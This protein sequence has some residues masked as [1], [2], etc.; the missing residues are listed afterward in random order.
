MKIKKI[1]KID[2]NGDVFN[3]RI[4]DDTELNHNYFA[5]N[6]C[7][8]NCH[9]A[10][11]ATIQS[12]L[13]RTLGSAK[14]RFGMSGTYPSDTSSEWLS[15]VSLHGPKLINISA[16]KLM[17]KGLI[18]PVKIKA[19]LLHHDNHKFAEGV[20]NIKKRGDGQKAW[21][22]EREYV[23]N[24]AKRKTFIKNLVDK[25][26]SNSLILF[27]TI[28]YGTEMFNFLKDNCQDKD[29]FYIDGSTSVEKRDYIKKKMEDTS[30]NPKIL[31]ASFGTTST[32]V[33]IKA[34][35]NII[36]AQAFKSD[37]VIRQSIGRG[38]RLHSEKNKLVVFDL[39]DV[40]H[41]EYK[42]ILI[43]QYESRRDD[44]YKKQKYPFDEIKVKL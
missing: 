12:V 32:G 26:K 22:L 33:N 44:I 16:K 7:V 24:S 37:Q 19:I 39:V 41:S 8:S 31:V 20:Y 1:S 14:I 11:A 40:F 5:N 43:K 25:F 10:K 23:A 27:H 17:D 38:L 6:L 42:T 28:E 18:S 2:Y 36:F 21:Q 29:I 15:I 35:T 13:Q 34:I 3:L 30:G 4:K 9:T